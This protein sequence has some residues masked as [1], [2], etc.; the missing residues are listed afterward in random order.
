MGGTASLPKLSLVLQGV[1]PAPT[2]ILPVSYNPSE[3]VAKG[4]AIQASLISDYDT[5][6]IAEAIHPIVTV[7]D[8]L[9]S[10]IGVKMSEGKLDLILES[11]TAIPCRGKRVYQC[12]EGGDVVLEVYEGKR[13]TE[14]VATPPTP[15]PEE[16]EE[17]EEPVKRRIVVPDKHIASLRVRGVE[18]GA[19]V[20]VQI[21][22]DSDGRTVIVGRE[23]GRKDAGVT[24]GTIEP[25]ET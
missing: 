23:L 24:K 7:V 20:E 2:N 11:D 5:Q 21:Q 16:D 4:A 6:T 15:P 9:V 17:V 10:P 13:E 3:L 1:F 18:K 19:T 8:H 12:H 25:K 22:V 14:V